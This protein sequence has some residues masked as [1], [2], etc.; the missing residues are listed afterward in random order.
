MKK[1]SI[2]LISFSFSFTLKAQPNCNFVHKWVPND[3][4]TGISF[5]ASDT[6]KCDI[7]TPN[8]NQVITW[9]MSEAPL[10]V[11]EGWD[12]YFIKS[13]KPCYPN[14]KPIKTYD[15]LSSTRKFNCHGYA[16]L[17]V[18]QG[19]DRWIGYGRTDLGE[20]VDPEKAYMTDGSYTKVSQHVYPGKVYW[21]GAGE[22]HSAITTSHPDTVISKWNA[23]PLAKHYLNDNP[24]HGSSDLNYYIRTSSI[25]ISSP[26]VVCDNGSFSLTVLPVDPITWTLIGPFSFDPNSSVKTI[27]TQNPIVY[28]TSASGD[29]GYIY[30]RVNGTLVDRK[31]IHTCRIVGP[32]EICPDGNYY[33]NTGETVQQW[34]VTNNNY[35]I[36]DN[37]FQ[38]GIE[39]RAMKND[40]TTIKATTSNGKV[41]TK[42]ISSCYPVIQ[43]P[44]IVC[45]NFN[46]FCYDHFGYGFQL[47][48]TYSYYGMTANWVIN[49]SSGFT[50]L[51]VNNTTSF[52]PLPTYNGAQS[53]SLT[54]SNPNYTA[55]SYVEAASPYSTYVKSLLKVES[56]CNLKVTLHSG[57][58]D[59]DIISAQ[60]SH[61]WGSEVNVTK[62]YSG[63]EFTKL[64]LNLDASNCGGSYH[65][66]LIWVWLYQYD[67][68]DDYT[69][70]FFHTHQ[71][72]INNGLEQTIDLTNSS[73]SLIGSLDGY[74][75]VYDIWIIPW[76][77]SRSME[78]MQAMGDSI[79]SAR[80]VKL[81]ANKPVALEEKP[82][83]FE[84]MV[85]PNPTA[86]IL[87]IEVASSQNGK[88]A[89]DYDIR[90]YDGQGNLLRQKKTKVNTVQFNVSN[91]P[92]GIYY[93]HIHDGVSDTP[94]IRQIMVER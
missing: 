44:I 31:P 80:R 48:Y 28:K 46:W 42:K 91:L 90:L 5:S 32:D 10:I 50:P 74:R 16:W 58:D 94:E 57:Y 33:L 20:P 69:Q 34:M 49:S 29:Y 11:R 43:G 76:G 18:E 17:R 47:P 62:I 2:L 71:G 8:N 81:S 54:A 72:V 66:Y 1:L 15:N 23:W 30:A 89:L 53:A 63:L 86:G 60:P 12:Y 87:N 68:N 92:N 79:R 51:Q 52:N 6:L 39:V 27:T 78:S 56:P 19:I 14:A 41:Y 55:Y 70:L 82:S 85:Y 73:F 25:T 36:L 13:P 4:I 61:F 64:T 67:W 26:D 21:G 38:N 77:W 22:D 3:H 88:T 75:F 40:T 45:P 59:R 93:L 37:A 24:F 7:R 9:A 65:S 83:N 84:M 35:F